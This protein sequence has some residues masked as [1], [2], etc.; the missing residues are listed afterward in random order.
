MS[1][2]RV[3]LSLTLM[4]TLSAA[5]TLAQAPV[6]PPPP[7]GW[8][9][10]IGAGMALTSGNTDTSTVNVGYDV[11]RDHGTDILFR[12]TGVYLRGSSGGVS[13][14]DRSGAD[15]R[16]EYK[17]SPQ[18]SAFGMTTYA[19]DRFKDIDYLLA[20]TAG[21]TYKVVATARTEWATDGSLGMVFEKNTGFGLKSDGAIIAGEKL[22]HKFNDQTRFLH[23]ASAL[24]KVRHFDDA[25]YTLSAGIVTAVAA[26]LDL[27]AE[28]LNSY[29]NRPSN[30]L[31]KKSDQSIVLSVVYKY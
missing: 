26:H 18:L 9:G 28:F 14:V 12:S 3:V 27:K 23:A 11:L 10:S 6:P 2:L 22:T 19:R 29:K 21:L 24:W 17:L 31:L 13:N 25:F 16:V 4:A 20:P 1:C 8:T 7:P 30:P 15:A 5:P